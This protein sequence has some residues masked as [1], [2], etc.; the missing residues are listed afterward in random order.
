MFGI[1][2]FAISHA[3][4]T[5]KTEAE[6]PQVHQLEVT[7]W[8]C[9]DKNRQITRKFVTVDSHPE[10]SPIDRMATELQIADGCVPQMK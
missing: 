9:Y 1:A 5:T 8:V 4:Q 6:P 10:L 7:Q 2:A 3:P